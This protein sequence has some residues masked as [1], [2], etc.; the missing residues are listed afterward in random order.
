MIMDK[1]GAELAIALSASATCA[2]IVRGI[3][4]LSVHH[5]S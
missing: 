3:D 5:F 4:T 1:Q 2:L